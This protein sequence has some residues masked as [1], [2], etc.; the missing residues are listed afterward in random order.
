MQITVLTSVNT[1]ELK[2]YNIIYREVLNSLALFILIIHVYI[3]H[4]TNWV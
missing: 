3:S 4:T 2:K 1:L